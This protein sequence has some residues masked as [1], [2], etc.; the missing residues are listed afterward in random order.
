MNRSLFDLSVV[1]GL[2]L[3]GV[4]TSWPWAFGAPW[5]VIAIGLSLTVLLPQE[6]AH[7]RDVYRDALRHRERMVE[8][9]RERSE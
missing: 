8:L 3:G 5:W 9:R 6:S 4:A 7:R 2:A 1:K